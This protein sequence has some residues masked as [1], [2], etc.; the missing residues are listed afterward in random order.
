MTWT[1][2]DANGSRDWIADWERLHRAS[3]MVNPL[4]DPVFVEA[5]LEHFGHA[6]VRLA[7]LRCGETAQAMLLL[8]P[9]GRG[10]WTTF[11]PSQMPVTPMVGRC[12]R[13]NLQDLLRALP[14]YAWQLALLHWDSAVDADL[15]QPSALTD[16]VH[17]GTNMRV[18][19]AADFAAYWKAR[20]SKLR[21][22]VRRYARL[23]ESDG[24]V[25]RTEELQAR[26]DM[27]PA[28]RAY[29]QL[30]SAGWKGR[31]GTAVHEENLQG[32]FYAAVM[33]AFASRGCARVLNLYFDEKLVASR[34]AIEGGG[35]AVMLKTAYDEGHRRYAPG[36]LLLRYAL[37]RYHE[38]DSVGAVEFY[39][40]ANRDQ[41][42]WATA[43][44]AT[45]HVNCYRNR[46]VRWLRET[47]RAVVRGRKQA[48]TDPQG[49]PPEED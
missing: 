8:D 41:L 4:V 29:G 48:A 20:P 26:E 2:S 36:R 39:T 11:Q 6:G 10:R 12:D 15:A 33:Q 24:L 49:T 13:G 46:A 37:E 38:I 22:N 23:A 1:L 16:P 28:V 7:T 25:L 34:L 31:Q 30:E 19:T 45:L 21:S 32:R 14:G 42:Q 3:A 27:G 44:R 40:N 17:H 9:A 47:A 35:T 43:Q 5:L 18:A